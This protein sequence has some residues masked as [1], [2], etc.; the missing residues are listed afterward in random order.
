MELTHEVQHDIPVLPGT[1]PIKQPPH[2]L[3]L[4]K[5]AEVGRQVE[6]LLQK[7]LIEPASGAWSSPVVLVKKKTEP[8]GSALTTG[9]STPSPSMTPIHCPG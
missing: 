1:I 3:G 2:R 9:D 6:G 5:E 8:G 7:G 4:E